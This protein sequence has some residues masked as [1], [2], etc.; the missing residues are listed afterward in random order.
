MLGKRSEKSVNGTWADFTLRKEKV[1]FERVEA[2]GWYFY[3]SELYQKWCRIYSS[4]HHPPTHSSIIH[5]S[6]N[7][8]IHRFPSVLPSTWCALLC[9]LSHRIC[10][11]R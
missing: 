3:D 10:G 4:I 5:V 1:L 8:F 11:I 7:L 9:P 6:I 2:V